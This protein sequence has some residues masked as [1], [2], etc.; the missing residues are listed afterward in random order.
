MENLLNFHRPRPKI[1]S[2]PA[3]QLSLLPQ[4]QPPTQHRTMP[5]VIR[6]KKTLTNPSVRGKRPL[7]QAIDYDSLTPTQ[8]A[9][10]DL[11]MFGRIELKNI[12]GHQYYYLRW[13]DPDTKKI[14]STYLGRTWT[15]A[16]AKLRKLINY[17]PT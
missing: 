13:A 3:D 7:S 2:R 5:E 17:T 4:P 10:W 12:K 15:V 14:R 6:D 9:R 8:Q 1:K 11:G 16:I